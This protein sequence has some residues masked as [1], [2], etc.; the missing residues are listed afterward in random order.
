MSELINLQTQIIRGKLILSSISSLETFRGQESR[1]WKAGTEWEFHSNAPLCPGPESIE[2]CSHV[3]DL[4]MG[5]TAISV[6]L[7]TLNT[8]PKLGQFLSKSHLEFS[9]SLYYT[10][11]LIPLKQ[12]STYWM[13]HICLEL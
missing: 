3:L 13:S 8:I 6:N 1:V 10:Q 12:S 11:F 7:P 4:S 9:H 5:M 2:Y